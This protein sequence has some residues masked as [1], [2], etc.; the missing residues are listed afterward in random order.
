[1]KNKMFKGRLQQDAQEFLRCLLSQ[2]HEEIGL[3]IPSTMECV[4]CGCGQE[5]CDHL[6]HRDSAMSSASHESNTSN[7]SSTKLVV[8]SC[9]PP[10]NSSLNSSPSTTPK[11]PLKSRGSYSK[12]KGVCKSSMESI[13]LIGQSRVSKVSLSK[14]ESQRDSIQ[15]SEVAE[16]CDVVW[17]EGEV[18][19]ADL[20]TCKVSRHPSH[21]DVGTERGSLV[22]SSCDSPPTPES[23]T[24]TS[25]PRQMSTTSVSDAASV[26]ET[27][28]R[29]PP[30]KP[31][32]PHAG[33]GVEEPTPPVVLR[34]TNSKPKSE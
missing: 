31:R 2:V 9:D 33:L 13:N 20:E 25:H 1:M 14:R 6:G 15:L 12:L 22:S 30:S 23:D 10:N 5:S 16:C 32:P 8:A 21:L 11:F 29:T 4:S 19:L 26:E 3:L 18:F 27:P 34:K 7:D 17:R 28:Y 24:H